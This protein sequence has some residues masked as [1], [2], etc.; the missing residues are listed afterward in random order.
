MKKRYEKHEALHICNFVRLFNLVICAIIPEHK[1]RHL[2]SLVTTRDDF[3][4][5]N[6]NILNIDLDLLSIL[7]HSVDP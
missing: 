4:S 7:F 3:D 1:I 2:Y 6:F 5:A